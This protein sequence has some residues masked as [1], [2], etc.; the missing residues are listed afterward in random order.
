MARSF[1]TEP[2]T[3]SVIGIVI[4]VDGMPT[5]MI[6]ST[7]TK[8]LETRQRKRYRARVRAWDATVK[9]HEFEHPILDADGPQQARHSPGQD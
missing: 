6:K 1:E 5:S 4:I 2:V 3:V 8:T 9:A 7:S